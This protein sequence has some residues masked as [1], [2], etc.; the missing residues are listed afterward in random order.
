MSKHQVVFKDESIEL[1]DVESETTAKVASIQLKY[2]QVCATLE[3]TQLALE[4]AKMKERMGREEFERV[5]REA[6]RWRERYESLV[7]S[8][9]EDGKRSNRSLLRQDHPNHPNIYP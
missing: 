7:K 6:V 3:Q 5:S 4:E 9:K 2:Q 8:G 1:R